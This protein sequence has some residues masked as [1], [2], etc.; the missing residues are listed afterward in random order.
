MSSQS[1]HKGSGILASTVRDVCP[2][3]QEAKEKFCLQTT[4]G[5]FGVCKPV[6]EPNTVFPSLAL[7]VYLVRLSS[8]YCISTFIK[9]QRLPINPKAQQHPVIKISQ[10]IFLFF[11][12]CAVIFNTQKLSVHGRFRSHSPPS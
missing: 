6:W 3:S 10:C 9:W 8:Q 1:K 4:R 11:L 5:L 2:C 12:H 7:H